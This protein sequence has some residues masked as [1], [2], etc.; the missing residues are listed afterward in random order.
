MSRLFHTNLSKYFVTGV[1]FSGKSKM[2]SR[3]F[4]FYTLSLATGAA[5]WS[6]NDQPD[7][8]SECDTF[9]QQTVNI[10]K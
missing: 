6:I 5:T 7:F 1:H 9:Q 10:K 3:C 4:N 2:K 8:E